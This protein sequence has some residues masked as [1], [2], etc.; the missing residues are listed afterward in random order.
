MKLCQKACC[1]EANQMIDNDNYP[2]PKI[3]AIQKAQY[4]LPSDGD[5]VFDDTHQPTHKIFQYRGTA[6]NKVGQGSSADDE[7]ANRLARIESMLEQMLMP[8]EEINSA[9]SNY[10]GDGQGRRSFREMEI[11]ER[12]RHSNCHYCGKQGHWKNECRL[13]FHNSQYAS[14]SDN[15]CSDDDEFQDRSP[16]INTIT[17]KCNS[18]NS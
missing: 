4:S 7:T 16:R 6:D 1:L 12:Q 14:Q 9:P 15:E 5:N 2:Q 8:N 17:T 18:N 10:Y 3:A 11:A 13:R